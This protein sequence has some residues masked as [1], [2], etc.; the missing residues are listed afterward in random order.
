MS[1]IYKITTAAEW[2]EAERTGAFRGS[3]L[4]L[5]DGYIHL[6]T[7]AQAGETARRHFRDQADLILLGFEVEALGDALK[8]E[9]SRGGQMFPHLYGV[10]RPD[11]AVSRRALPLDA[12][13]APILPALEP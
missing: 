1:R 3:A 12:E 5:Q 11:H 13:G 8:W 2:A 10:L 4:D 7:A 9:P 6:S